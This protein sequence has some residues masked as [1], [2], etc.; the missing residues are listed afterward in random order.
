MRPGDTTFDR[1]YLTGMIKHHQGA[2]AMVAE[3]FATPGG[4]QQADLFGLA[5]DVD[6][7]QRVEIARMQAMLNTLNPTSHMIPRMMPRRY[8]PLSSSSRR[9]HS[10]RLP[11]R[12]RIPPTRAPTSRPVSTTPASPRRAWSSSRTATSRTCSI[13]MRPG[14]SRTRTRTWRSGATTSTRAISAASRSGISPTRRTRRWPHAEVCFTEQGDVSIEGHLLFVWAENTG[15]RL[16]CGMQGV[17]DSV[18]KDRMVGIRIFNV[19]DPKNPKQVADIQT[20]RGSHTHTLVP[21]PTDKGVVYVYV[22]GLARV[23]SSSEMAGLRRDGGVTD[24]T[25]AM[26]RI[27]II[28]VPLANP[29]SARIVSTAR[30][31]NDLA[32]ATD[33]WSGVRRH[34]QRGGVARS[35]AVCCRRCRPR[36]R[37]PTRCTSRTCS[38]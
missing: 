38:R 26:F 34:G 17:K 6:A 16:D 12:S 31:F 21:D 32:A 24:P 37:R 8:R 9:W 29:A 4:G 1:L 25:S 36:H 28:R 22:S 5:T 18:S 10:P 3:L 33:A 35:A 20:C 2:I 30:I 15:S 7:G 13:P 19:S 11:S 27:E 23:R 14:G